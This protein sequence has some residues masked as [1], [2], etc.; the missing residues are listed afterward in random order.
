[1]RLR[2]EE[3]VATGTGQPGSLSRDDRLI[4]FGNGRIKSSRT[5]TEI[6]AEPVQITR[7]LIGELL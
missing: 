7:S 1:M 6:V 5:K 4:I 2:R 3:V